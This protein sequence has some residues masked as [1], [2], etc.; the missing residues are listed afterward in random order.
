M[1]RGLTV[2]DIDAQHSFVRVE[3]GSPD[4]VE[5]RIEF[6]KAGGRAKILIQRRKSRGS[7]ICNHL[8]VSRVSPG[9]TQ[10]IFQLCR[11]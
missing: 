4:V 1:E 9:H 2:A 7:R 6:Q 11:T 10:A 8:Y 3:P 5:Q